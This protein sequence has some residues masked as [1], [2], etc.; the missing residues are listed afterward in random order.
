LGSRFFI[1]APVE[2]PSSSASY[3]DRCV[4]VRLSSRALVV[5]FLLLAGVI[6]SNK[7]GTLLVVSRPLT[8]PDVV[9]SLSSHEWERLPAA[10]RLASANPS[11]TVLLTLP[12][13]VSEFNCHDCSGRVGRLKHLGVS[14]QRVRI[15]PL[16]SPG[17]FGEARAA[18]AFIR[19]A[20]L[21]R[22]V[23][24]TTP[25]H[26]RRALATFESVFGGSGVEIGIEPA[27]MWSQ[28]MP[29]R[30]W[31]APYDRWYVAYEWAGIFY[32][33]I[34]YRVVSW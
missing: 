15:L 1:S 4:N 29:E 21:Q 12:Q 28:A 13:Q 24:V 11:S 33:A 32:Y 17:T 23:I 18:L 34:R 7:A 6:A 26:T 31:A 2:N 8:R 20:H 5:G 22:L 14:E 27:T 9:L 30:W 19:E 25:Y 16:T 10:A 3:H